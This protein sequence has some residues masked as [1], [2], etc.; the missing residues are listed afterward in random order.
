MIECRNQVGAPK[1]APRKELASANRV[2]KNDHFLIMQFRFEKQ[3][4]GEVSGP[5]L[6][7]AVQLD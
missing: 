5:A 7:S 6:A 2:K 1:V 3:G 4:G